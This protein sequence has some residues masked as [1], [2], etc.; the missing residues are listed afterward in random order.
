MLLRYEALR[1]PAGKD[2]GDDSVLLFD[3]DF[4][5]YG[6]DLDLCYRIQEAGWKIF[7]TPD[8][9]IIHFKGQSTKKSDLVYVRHFYGAMLLFARKHFNERYSSLVGW[10]LRAGI[11]IRAGVSILSNV[12]RRLRAP[13]TDAL[14]VV[15]SVTL[16]GLLRTAQLGT[17][18]SGLFLATI[19][20]AYAVVTALATT[21]L[22]GYVGGTR[23]LR[24][25]LAGLLVGLLV[26][27]AL[28]FFVKGIA[29]SRLIVVLTYPVAA[30]GLAGVRILS[31]RVRVHDRKALL[32]GDR[33]E[34]ARLGELLRVHPNPPFKLVGFVSAVDP[35][36][37]SGTD[38][39]RLGDPE[40]TR[41]L[42]RLRYIDD[43][44]FA[45]ASLTNHTMLEMMR[46]LRDLP[47][48]FRILVADAPQLIARSSVSDL[49]TPAI[50]EASAVLRTPTVG[51]RHALFERT[52]AAVGLGL[53][54]WLLLARTVRP[55]PW[56]EELLVS[57][58]RFPSV[59][60]GRLSLVGF[61]PDA[62]F[63][64]P[65]EWNLRPGVFFVSD[66]VEGEDRLPDLRRTYAFYGSNRSATLDL[67][68]MRRGLSRRSRRRGRSA[69]S[70]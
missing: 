36:T 1:H 31:R 43:I 67:E 66:A 34:A 62:E 9:Q 4:F 53:F 54:P 2:S 52:I 63:V 58:R 32:V 46:S 23:P 48:R 12:L 69:D 14:T 27:S 41:D 37:D 60:S 24:P 5:M 22:G 47:V 61:N 6:E 29:F 68:V 16:V 45:A 39:S 51:F 33:T 26:V 70:G 13:I 3:E 18:V 64:P 17:D 44:V 35:D 42:V 57:V 8:T 10:T 15:A 50:V 59:L 49:S 28:S 21:M 55:T 20:A 65:P 19:P 56:M 7:Y 38:S 40:Q 11:R 25:A 30:I